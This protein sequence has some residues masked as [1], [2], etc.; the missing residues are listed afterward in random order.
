MQGRTPAPSRAG[1]ACP[2]PAEPEI[3][4]EIRYLARTASVEVNVQDERLL[5]AA[6]GLLPAGS[7]LYVSHL[8]GQ[9]WNSTVSLCRAVRQAGFEPVPHVPVRLFRS[10]AEL[11][12]V[13]QSI[14][15]AARPRGAL[16]IAG[17]YASTQG[18]YECTSMV[19]ESG[20]LERAGFCEV[21]LAG[22]PEGHPVVPEAALRVSER[23]KPLIAANHGLAATFLTQFLFEARPFLDWADLLRSNGTTTRIV[24]GMTGPASVST[25]FR[26]A[27][28]CGVGRSIR[29][30]GARPSTLRYLAGEH[31][32][33]RMLRE[34][35]TA[36]AGRKTLFDGVHF[37]SFGGFVRTLEWL[38]LE[39]R[40]SAIGSG[41]DQ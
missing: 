4:A 11:H 37:F 5:D 7:T 16:L 1:K 31:R 19:L 30:L 34:L 20:A 36:R 24:C 15:Q 28:R 32:P 18:P 12:Q 35:A 23:T 26:Y 13:L 41:I 9:G 8:P 6:R 25:L 17:D 3:L 14:V 27:R 21:A 22:H 38:A 29:A 40:G 10:A 33:D 39:A 2:S